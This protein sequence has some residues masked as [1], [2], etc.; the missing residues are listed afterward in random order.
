MDLD[1]FRETLKAWHER[2]GRNQ[3]WLAG[4][5]GISANVISRWEGKRPTRPMPDNL[6]K[7]APVIEVPYEDLMRMCGYMPGEAQKEVDRRRQRRSDEL[8]RWIA[9]VGPEYEDLFWDDLKGRARTSIR[10][11]EQS[12]TAVK[13]VEDAAVNN[14]VKSSAKRGRDNG[15]RGN[16]PLTKSQDT[17]A[18]GFNPLSGIDNRRLV[19]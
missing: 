10:L 18:L 12:R 15:K 2:T 14:G 5:T 4:Q 13:S 8:E 11:F 17:T 9:A 6:A 1:E 19:A 3:A 7:L 16:G